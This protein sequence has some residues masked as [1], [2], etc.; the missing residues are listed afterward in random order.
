MQLAGEVR[1]SAV[2]EAS[3]DLERGADR[4]MSRMRQR[5]YDLV[6]ELSSSR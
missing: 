5:I 3:G 2:A 6:R 4:F 1:A